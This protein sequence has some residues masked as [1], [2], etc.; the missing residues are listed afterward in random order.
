MT[1]KKIIKIITLVI[2]LSI[3]NLVK[4]EQKTVYIDIDLIMKNSLAGKSISKQLEKI[5]QSNIINFKKSEDDLRLEEKQ[6]VS[7]KNVLSETEYS[8]K[9]SFLRKKIADYNENKKK[10]VNSLN[11]KQITAQASLINSL[12]PILADYS[13]ENSITM[14]ISKKNII[15]GK[16]ELDI[17]KDIL[18]IVDNKIKKIDLN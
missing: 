1:Y 7:Q 13:K 2:F 14:I 8:K 9:V 12:T 11:K 5:N 10:I 4:A 17:T 18:K 15:M 6:I 3:S 16:N